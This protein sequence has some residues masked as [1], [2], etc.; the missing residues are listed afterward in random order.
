MAAAVECRLPNRSAR[1]IGNEQSISIL[2]KGEAVGHYRL[3]TLSVGR[4][5]PRLCYGYRSSR[6][7]TDITPHAADSVD[8]IDV[9][10]HRLDTKNLFTPLIRMHCVF[11]HTTPRCNLPNS[12]LTRR[13]VTNPE[14]S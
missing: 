5:T 2:V 7:R 6:Q 1:L 9:I 8:E 3:G 10:R 11:T 13:S 4:I 14:V 12:S